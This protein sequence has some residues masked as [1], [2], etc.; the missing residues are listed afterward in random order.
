[1]HSPNQILLFCP[2]KEQFENPVHIRTTASCEGIEQSK[3]IMNSAPQILDY[4]H[5]FKH[6][7]QRYGGTLF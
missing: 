7:L 1:M 2:Q 3:I 4:Q 5:N 6:E